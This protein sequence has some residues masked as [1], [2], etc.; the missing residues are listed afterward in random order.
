M[1]LSHRAEQPVGAPVGLPPLPSP[2]A[3]A[4]PTGPGRTLRGLGMGTAASGWCQGPS[5]GA[6]SPPAPAR[7][8]AAFV[9]LRVPWAGQAGAR[10][11]PPPPAASSLHPGH[12]Y[13]CT[14]PGWGPSGE[15][16]NLISGWKN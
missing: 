12:T 1:G 3:W 11:L 9:L 10:D 13:W 8:T 7:L 14:A 15:G 6:H 5:R 16:G 4:H 2:K